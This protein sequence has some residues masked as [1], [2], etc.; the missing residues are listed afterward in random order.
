MSARNAAIARIRII[1]AI[2]MLAALVLVARLYQLQIISFETY[3]A[4]GE[5][6]YVHT[7]RNLYDRGSIYFTTRDGEKVS[8]AT[9]QSGY[10]L[11]VDPSRINDAEAVYE[12]LRPHLL[13]DKETFIHRATLPNRVDVEVRSEV[14][15]EEAMKIKELN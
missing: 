13:I 6:Q 3:V 10:T 12:A 15:E 14:T 11:S 2:F 8:A 9:I 4:H 1:T 5:S 7:V